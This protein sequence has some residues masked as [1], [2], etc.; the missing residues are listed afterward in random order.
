M[1]RRHRQILILGSFLIAAAAGPAFAQNIGPS[2]TVEPYILPSIDGVKTTSLLTV[3]DLPADN[4]Y[5]MVGIPDGLGAFLNIPRRGRPAIN[6]LMN[7]ELGASAGIVRAHGSKG[8]FVSSWTISPFTLR[9]T[10]GE[11]LVQSLTDIH[12]WDTVTNQYTTG[13]TTWDRFC[14]SDLPARGAFSYGWLG[15]ESRIYMNGE[16]VDEGRAFAHIASGNHKGEAWQL[17]R[18]GK[19]SYENVVASPHPQPKTVVML[20]DDASVST[21]PVA[22]N[23]PSELYAYVGNKLKD[24]HPVEKAGL[25]NGKLYGVKVML[26]DGAVVG[27]EDNL[28]GLGNAGSGYIGAGKFTLVELGPGGNVSDWSALQLEEASIA[29]NIFRMQRV[30]DGAWDPRKRYR[31]DFYFLTT[32]SFTT[33]S[34]LWRLNF[35]NI[36]KPELGGK[37]E[38]LL[39]GDE[40]HRMLDNMTV[41]RCGRVLM[42]EDPGNQ[43]HLAKIWLYGIKSGNL[44]E[45]A[46]HNPKFFD[47][48]APVPATF[49]TRDEESSGIIP[50][51]RLL[52]PGWYL[53]DSEAHL[54]HPD[55]E[56]VQYGQLLAMY[57]D[58]GL[59]CDRDDDDD[60]DDDEHEEEKD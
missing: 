12:L 14:S 56:L 41:D 7:H 38:I 60:N 59:E 5:R 11:D 20:L 29:A 35:Y 49:I 52:G 39:K 44:I 27:G 48:T 53:L 30:E 47:P 15:T 23:F 19:M 17:P 58:P 4:G 42:Q 25:T 43:A 57:V 9:V 24:G 22:A 50:A 3:N 33:H 1:F 21:A 6:L 32:A 10:K 55:P 26:N 13:T 51:G 45:I 37:I 40:G 31:D 34:R 8:A 46:H 36:E 16:E 54:A 2:T 28:Y 18:F